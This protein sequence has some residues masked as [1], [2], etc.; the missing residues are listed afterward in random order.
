[1]HQIGENIKDF[2]VREHMNRT[3]S[4]PQKDNFD[5]RGSH[6]HTERKR[7]PEVAL[8]MDKTTAVLKVVS[9]IL[10][11]TITGRTKIKKQIQ[12]TFLEI[13]LVRFRKLR[14]GRQER[15]QSESCWVSAW[16]TR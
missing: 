8:A 11:T 9:V 12:E 3:I 16:K 1:M 5:L 4:T 7:R 15:N 13:K 2:K 10:M 6:T 14:C